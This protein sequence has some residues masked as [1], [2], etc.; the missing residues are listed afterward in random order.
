MKNNLIYLLLIFAFFSCKSVSYESAV[1]SNKDKFYGDN[2]KKA[3]LLDNFKDLSQVTSDISGLADKHAYSKDLCDFAH[4]VIS[5]QQ[6]MKV[7]LRI[8]AV[9]KGIKLPTVVDKD[10]QK[11]YYKLEDVNDEKTFDREY[12]S[13]MNLLFSD[14]INRCDT[15]IDNQNEGPVRDFIVKQSGIY[16]DYLKKIDQLQGYMNKKAD[17]TA[18]TEKSN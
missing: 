1:N 9:K 8:L 11:I 4:M 17:E 18:I 15:F 10:N 12:Y 13:N 16:K 14:I 6:R 2:K 5:D 7:P 3:L